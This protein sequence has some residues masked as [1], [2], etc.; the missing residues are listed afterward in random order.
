MIS[1][2]RDEILKSPVP[3]GLYMV[4]HDNEAQY[5][6]DD[7]DVLLREHLRRLDVPYRLT[8]DGFTQMTFTGLLFAG[9]IDQYF[10]NMRVVMHTLMLNEYYDGSSLVS[11]HNPY[12]RNKIFEQWRRSISDPAAPAVQSGQ[13]T[14]VERLGNWKLDNAW[15]AHAWR[16]IKVDFT[17]FSKNPIINWGEKMLPISIREEKK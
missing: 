8:T 9:K 5:H 6:N 4:Y 17:K 14:G 15:P 7:E 16:M 10:D 2:T 1:T 13:L 3:E 12:Y 11:F